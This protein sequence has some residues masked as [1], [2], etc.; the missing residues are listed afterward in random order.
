VKEKERLLNAAEVGKLLGGIH[1]NN[2]YK[3]AIRGELP[4]LKIGRRVRFSKS[5]II[6]WI[7]KLRRNNNV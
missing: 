3:M 4:S 5:E 6:I 7:K 2:V 1:P